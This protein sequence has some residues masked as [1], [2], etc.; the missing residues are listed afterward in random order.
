MGEAKRRPKDK[1][2][3]RVILTPSG[4]AMADKEDIPSFGPRD[5]KRG[6]SWSELLVC[7]AEAVEYHPALRLG[8]LRLPKGSCCDM[9]GCI[10]LFRRLDPDVRRIETFSGDVRDTR[11]ERDGNGK[12]DAATWLK[13]VDAEARAKRETR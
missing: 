5:Q 12:W 8:V 13:T 6:A 1:A 3:M 2:M 10:E 4:Y 7:F 11:Y 9:S